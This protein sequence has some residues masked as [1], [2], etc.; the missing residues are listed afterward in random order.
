MKVTIHRDGIIADKCIYLDQYQ[1]HYKSCL[2]ILV[3]LDF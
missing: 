2:S 1:L 3:V